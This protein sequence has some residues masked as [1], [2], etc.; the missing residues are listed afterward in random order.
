MINKSRLI[1]KKSTL[2]FHLYKVWEE[3]N[4]SI[5][6]QL[7]EQLLPLRNKEIEPPGKEHEGIFW[8]DT[9]G[10]ILMKVSVIQVHAFVKNNGMYTYE[11]CISSYINVIF[12]EKL[13]TEL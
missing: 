11:L 2:E 13:N 8:G 5:V 4:Q 10:L 7:S 9:K 12:K 1:Q 3:Q 6:E